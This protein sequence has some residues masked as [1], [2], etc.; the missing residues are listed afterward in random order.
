[1][2]TILKDADELL[3][4]QAH[5]IL[6]DGDVPASSVFQPKPSDENRLSVDRSALTNP[7]AAYRLF[8]GNGFLSAAVY[9][10]T[11]GEFLNEQIECLEDPLPSIELNSA[12]P[13]HAVAIYGKIL[14]NRQKRAA[15][16]LKQVAL[17]RGKLY[18]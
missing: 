17:A 4:R 9:G 11:V 3:F 13:A 12:N 16:R 8:V 18:P 14:G 5:P 10:L 1:M 15:Q 7:E 6:M 2:P